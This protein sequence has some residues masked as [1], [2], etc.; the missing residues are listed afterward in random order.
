MAKAP[1]I[2]VKLAMLVVLADP[3]DRDAAR[4]A[5]TA[6]GYEIHEFQVG[7]PVPLPAQ[8]RNT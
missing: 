3:S 2:Q 7:V 5:L 1:E 6:A 8:H 4:Q